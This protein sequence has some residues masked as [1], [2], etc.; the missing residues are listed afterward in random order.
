[1][2]EETIEEEGK[3]KKEP[4]QTCENSAQEEPR[5]QTWVSVRGGDSVKPESAPDQ[6]RLFHEYIGRGGIAIFFGHDSGAS[7]WPVLTQELRQPLSETLQRKH[8]L[9]H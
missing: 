3:K 5:D 6:L 9:S 2:W 7:R 4:T 1:M 8:S